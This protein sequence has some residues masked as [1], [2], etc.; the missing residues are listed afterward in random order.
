MIPGRVA[1][2]LLDHLSLD[3]DQ[4]GNVFGILT[5]QVGQQALKVEVHVAL[6]GLGLQRA[7]IGHNE[8]IQTVDHLMEHVEGYDTIAQ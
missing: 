3:I 5:G 7:L 1:D 6:A 8:L 4:G 2:K